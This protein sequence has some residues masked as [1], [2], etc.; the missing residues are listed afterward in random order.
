MADFMANSGDLND[1]R[2]SDIIDIPNKDFYDSDFTIVISQMS[3]K[4]LAEGQPPYYSVRI[5]FHYDI[6]GHHTMEI[7]GQEQTFKGVLPKSFHGES[8][9]IQQVQDGLVQAMLKPMVMSPDAEV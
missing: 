3:L 5:S 6:N 9:E 4:A 8:E 2:Q 1:W 7:S